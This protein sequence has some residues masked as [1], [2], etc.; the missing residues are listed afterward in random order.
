MPLRVEI[1][2]QIKLVICIGYFYHLAKVSGLESRLEPQV[3]V[4]VLRPGCFGDEEDIVPVGA[5]GRFPGETC[6]ER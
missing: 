3:R 4:V 5:R 6:R 1:S 2:S